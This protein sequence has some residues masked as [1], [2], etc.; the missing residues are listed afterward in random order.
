MMMRA[1]RALLECPG[2]AHEMTWE[3]FF[4]LYDH[5]GQATWDDKDNAGIKNRLNNIRKQLLHT[6][7]TGLLAGTSYGLTNVNWEE[8]GYDPG[9]FK[10]VVNVMLDKS[11]GFLTVHT[12]EA[13]MNMLQGAERFLGADHV[14]S[15]CLLIQLYR[16]LEQYVEELTSIWPKLHAQGVGNKGSASCFAASGHVEQ[17]AD[18]KV[19]G[20]AT[21]ADV[22]SDAGSEREEEASAASAKHAMACKAASFGRDIAARQQLKQEAQDQRFCWNTRSKDEL[23]KYLKFLG[24][25]DVHQAD[26][27][28]WRPLFQQVIL[29]YKHSV[30]MQHYFAAQVLLP[31]WWPT[32]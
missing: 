30:N 21:E 32:F 26:I 15:G 23:Q 24:K 16:M 29:N 12:A 20:D 3:C 2:P 31:C 18:E 7:A 25:P 14:L 19:E 6:M 17:S 28:E 13:L 27:F 22:A 1:A 4:S 5:L 11:S 10:E 9:E 8:L